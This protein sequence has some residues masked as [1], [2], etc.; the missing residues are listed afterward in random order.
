M[1]EKD[2]VKKYIGDFKKGSLDFSTPG[3]A[4]HVIAV[5]EPR[6]GVY[7][8]HIDAASGVLYRRTMSRGGIEVG[9]TE[10]QI[11]RREEELAYLMNRQ[12]DAL[13]IVVAAKRVSRQ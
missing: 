10:R 2:Q 7:Q 5:L 6:L 1:K 11:E 12:F 13:D 4:E 9:L 3:V 8:R